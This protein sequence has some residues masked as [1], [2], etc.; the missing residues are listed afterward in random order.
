MEISKKF[1]IYETD[2][3]NVDLQFIKLNLLEKM[4]SYQKSAVH[5]LWK[6]EAENNFESGFL[7]WKTPYRFRHFVT[8]KYLRLPSNLRIGKESENKVKSIDFRKKSKKFVIF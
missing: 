1:E 5:S 8:G 3:S 4:A 7:K 6:I 2:F